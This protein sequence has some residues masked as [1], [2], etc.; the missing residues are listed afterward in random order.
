MIIVDGN[1]TEKNI[2]AFANLEEILKDVMQDETMENRIV[3]DVLVNNEA[4]SEIYP[5]QAEDIE[6]SNITSVE[7]RSM[8]VSEMAVEMSAE[9]G[10]V[11]NMMEHGA[12]QVSRLFRQAADTDAL[13]LFQ[14]LLDVT[15]DFMGMLGELR[16][17]Y[18]TGSLENFTEK[19]EEFS[20]LLSEMGDVLENEDWVLLADLL[21]YE[22]V[23][24]CE[25]W[26]E[27]SEN[28]HLQ[29]SGLLAH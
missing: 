28:L 24:L 18:A 7:V 9:M 2:A 1:R 16:N 5:H 14:D 11:A 25:D 10:K 23:P 12:R 4:F 13:E 29:V 20:N 15:R 27:I 26:H 8:P 21:E 6:S 3:T 17:R 22:F 19:T